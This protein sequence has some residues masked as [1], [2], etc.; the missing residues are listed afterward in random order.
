MNTYDR[1]KMIRKKRGMN[2]TELAI[3]SGYAEKSMIARI[4][5]GQIDLALSKL[6]SIARALNVD[7]AYLL[8]TNEDAMR[9]DIV[10]YFNE[11]NDEG[12]EKLCEYAKL[13]CASG[14]YKKHNS[15]EMVDK[16]A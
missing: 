4:E 12:K 11:L 13:L 7:P 14:E 9:E 8:G 2:Q 1:I 5:S 10:D 15:N 6:K 16:Q 3:K